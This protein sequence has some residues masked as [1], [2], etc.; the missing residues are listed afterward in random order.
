MFSEDTLMKNCTQAKMVVTCAQHG[1][2]VFPNVMKQLIHVALRH[3][4]ESGKKQIAY[5]MIYVRDHEIYSVWLIA[6]TYST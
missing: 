2:A 1:N 6:A 3:N 5:K 4:P